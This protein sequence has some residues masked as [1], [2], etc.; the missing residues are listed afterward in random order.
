MSIKVTH[1]FD[2]NSLSMVRNLQ[3]ID[4][5]DIEMVETNPDVFLI[6]LHDESLTFFDIDDKFKKNLLSLSN[7]DLMINYLR[8]LSEKPKLFWHTGIATVI[9][10]FIKDTDLV[11]GHGEYPHVDNFLGI[12]M[13]CDENRF[14]PDSKI[15]RIPRTIA[16]MNDSY[17]I[18]LLCEL[19]DKVIILG[20][21]KIEQLFRYKDLLQYRDKLETI[22]IPPENTNKMRE[23]LNSV[24]F[25]INTFPIS[26]A[27]RLGTEG[28]LSGAQ[29]IYPDTDFYRRRFDGL[30][31]I[32]YF[33][34]ESP[35]ETIPGAL[36]S[37]SSIGKSE[38][39]EAVNKLSASKHVP[40]FWEQ[41]K[42]FLNKQ[43]ADHHVHVQPE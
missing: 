14:Y 17:H 12:W 6:H 39:A 8:D 21:D 7:F 9:P 15:K 25:V 29:P 13:F 30:S 32:R 19:M 43:G 33:D 10:E 42:E 38:I 16:L 11:F 28:L 26:G 40:L 37:P 5:G 34:P 4:F 41:V 20:V 31:S 24:E 35:Y 3:L 1:T 23:I 22:R 2:L 36:A 27:E 18:R